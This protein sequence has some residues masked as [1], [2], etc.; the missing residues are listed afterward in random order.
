MFVK[1]WSA[2]V[3]VAASFATGA[4]AQSVADIGGPREL[5]PASYTQQ[6]YVDSRGCAFLR[7]GIGG[8]VRWVPRVGDNR[9]VICGLPPSLGPRTRVEV[10]EET[11]PAP[12]PAPTRTAVVEPPPAPAPSRT[13]APARVVT[14][15]PPSPAATAR[16]PV[17]SYTPAPVANLP[18]PTPAPVRVAPPVTTTRTADAGIERT[19]NGTT[20]RRIACTTSAPVAERV[21]LRDGGSVV[22]CTRGDGTL[23][24]WRSPIYLDGDKVGASLTPP[25]RDAAPAATPRY[26]PLGQTQTAARQTGTTRAPAVAATIPV[27]EGYRLAWDD[28][29]LNPLRGEGSARGQAQQDQIWTRKVP[30]TVVA[31]AKPATPVTRDVP[32]SDNRPARGGANAQALTALVMSTKGA[33]QASVDTTAAARPLYVQ[34]GAFGDPANAQGSTARLQAA[35]LPV[36]ISR[37]RGLQVVMAGPFASRGEAAQALSIARGAGFGDAFVR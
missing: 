3:L 10:A 7:A 11:A 25:P 6:Q 1:V 37:S 17:E 18:A 20:G 32:S 4:A 9:S 16:I 29:R 36:A 22:V 26:A 2:A 27:P 23:D 34:V 19:T 12:A 30:A 15:T 24:G 14:A 8:Q 33:P 13:V 21:A 5:P 28:D 35:G 31:D